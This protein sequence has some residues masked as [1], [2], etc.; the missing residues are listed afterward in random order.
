MKRVTGIGG[1]FF[2]ARKPVTPFARVMDPAG[3]QVELR[4]PPPGP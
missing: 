4:E 2:Q 1:I 3:R